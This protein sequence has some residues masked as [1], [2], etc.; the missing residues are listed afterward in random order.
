MEHNTTIH[1]QTLN[2][3]APSPGFLLSAETLSFPD[4]VSGMR[5][6]FTVTDGLVT[7][8]RLRLQWPVK[9]SDT[10][11]DHEGREKYAADFRLGGFSDWRQ[12]DRWELLSICK[13]GKQNPCVDTEIFQSNGDW[14]GTREVTPWSSDRV[15]IVGFDD[16]SVGADLRSYRAFCRPVRS[17]VAGQ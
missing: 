9:E 15:F 1:I 2:V 6:R 8:H 14:V 3:H 16:G 17:L 11:M 7:D 12:G 10:K 4:D 13:T 5:G